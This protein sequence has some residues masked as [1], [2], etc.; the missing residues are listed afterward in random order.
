MPI[1]YLLHLLQMSPF[2]MNILYTHATKLESMY[3]YENSLFTLLY[4]DSSD[5]CVWLFILGTKLMFW[6]ICNSKCVSV[7][8]ETRMVYYY[9]YSSRNSLYW[10]LID[11]ILLMLLH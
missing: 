11:I 5:D 4:I 1:I 2:I 3:N 10:I 9:F 6:Y 8:V 7:E